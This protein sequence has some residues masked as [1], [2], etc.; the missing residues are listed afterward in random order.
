VP[1]GHRLRTASAVLTAIARQAR[2]CPRNQGAAAAAL[3]CWGRLLA[4]SCGTLCGR[5]REPPWQTL[6]G[7]RGDLREYGEPDWPWHDSRLRHRCCR[8]AVGLPSW[9]LLVAWLASGTPWPLAG[10]AGAKPDKRHSSRSWSSEA[11]LW[12]PLHPHWS[13]GWRPTRWARGSGK[14]KGKASR[15]IR[16]VELVCSR[17]TIRQSDEDIQY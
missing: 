9:P 12:L 10:G 5:G 8:K 4:F 1:G 15:Y 13:G 3:V 2:V 7:G 17:S 16:K 14:G 6:P 11:F